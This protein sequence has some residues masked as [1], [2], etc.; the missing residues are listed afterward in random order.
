MLPPTA[1]S[2]PSKIESGH[3]H[4]CARPTCLGCVRYLLRFL[5]AFVSLVF[6]A[7][8]V[9][10]LVYYDFHNFWGF[11]NWIAKGTLG[12]L[13][14][15]AG[16]LLEIKG[17]TARKHFG[18][19][20]LNRIGSTIFYIWLGFYLMGVES[21]STKEEQW[22]KGLRAAGILS[23]IVAFFDLL[24]SCTAKGPK[25]QATEQEQV[26]VEVTSNRDATPG[27]L[28]VEH[29]QSENAVP[30][31]SSESSDL[32]PAPASSSWN[33]TSFKPFGTA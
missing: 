24:V 7:H 8:G 18:W 16:C 27:R 10:Q 33:N 25:K 4:F 29:G 15:F 14:G 31:S 9:W 12:I 20:A 22:V 17:H 32:Q 6:A 19:F 13:G 21:A 2:S 28:D 30:E 11:S 5:G 3:G 26:E 23:W 1:T